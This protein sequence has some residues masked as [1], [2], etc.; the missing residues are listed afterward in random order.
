MYA[1]PH[2]FQHLYSG[3]D[4]REAKCGASFGNV[5]IS[6]LDFADDAVI[7]VETG[8]PFG[9]LEM[10]NE[11]SELLGLQ[12]SWVKTKIQAFNDIL[13]V[14][15]LSVPVCGEDVEVRERFT[16]PGSDIHVSA[17]CELEVNRC[18]GRA[19]GVMGKSESSGLWCFQSCSMDVRLGL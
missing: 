8:Y 19:W 12:V 15:I 9:A 3:E 6:D 16:Y 13:D 18:L 10:L 14:A 1:G 7:F 11:E 2:T 5:K 4:V 17:G